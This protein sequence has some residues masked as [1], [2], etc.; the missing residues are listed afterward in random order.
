MPDNWQMPRWF[1][2]SRT[3]PLNGSPLLQRTAIVANRVP[4]FELSG[5]FT[6]GGFSVT[7]SSGAGLRC[8]LLSQIKPS[9]SS[10]VT[11]LLGMAT[12]PGCPA[13]ADDASNIPANPTNRFIIRSFPQTG[14]MWQECKHGRFAQQAGR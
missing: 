14:Q 9:G 5:I 11:A 3:S 12:W 1:L 6:F 8:A 13:P 10:V 4:R 7:T 2:V